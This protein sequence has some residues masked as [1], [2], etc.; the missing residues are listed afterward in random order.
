MESF[1]FHLEQTNWVAV[2]VATVFFYLIGGFWYSKAGF[3]NEWMKS[4]GL[5][6]T[7]A[8]KIRSEVTLPLS[9][10]LAFASVVALSVLMCALGLSTWL[11][12]VG[13]GTLV[14]LGFILTSQGVHRLFEGKSWKLFVIDGGFN[15][16]FFATAGAIIG[17]F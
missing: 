7:K 15:L 16:L 12:G 4:V 11:Q 5:T 2:V 3:G 17:I 6:K 9:G 14:G 13:L 10:A 1:T 8:K